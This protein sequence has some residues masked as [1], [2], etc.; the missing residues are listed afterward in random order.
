MG[1]LL[2]DYHYLARTYLPGLIVA[3]HDLPIGRSWYIK[4]DHTILIDSKL[5]PRYQ[6]L[7]TVHM[8][9]HLQLGHGSAGARQARAA[10]Q[11]REATRLGTEW[12]LPPAKLARLL[13]TVSTNATQIASYLGL[14]VWFL[15]AALSAVPR[16]YW[17]QV[18]ALTDLRVE[19][20]QISPKAIPQCVL[21]DTLPTMAAAPPG[22][23]ASSRTSAG[24][25]RPGQLTSRPAFADIRRTGTPRSSSRPE[26]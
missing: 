4:D 12:I 13:N 18:R 14:S 3:T 20:P 11:E 7:Q 10:Q 9:A 1:A 8:L 19:W 22:P 6:Q 17:Q 16:D 5:P 26:P 21:L 23:L 24:P 15:A 2:S 25:H